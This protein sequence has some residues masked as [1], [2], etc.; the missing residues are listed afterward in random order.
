MRLAGS[1]STLLIVILSAM[2]SPPLIDDVHARGSEPPFETEHKHRPL[3]NLIVVALIGSIIAFWGMWRTVPAA[4]ITG[5]SL[6][7]LSFLIGFFARNGTKKRLRFLSALVVVSLGAAAVLVPWYLA[8]HES[9]PNAIW[10]RDGVIA[11]EMLHTD[12]H[13]LVRDAGGITALDINTGQL[14]WSYKDSDVYNMF[15]SNDGHVL[16]SGKDLTW[17]SPDGEELWSIERG[18]KPVAAHG[19][20]VTLQTCPNDNNDN[21][22]S[23]DPQADSCFITS[24]DASNRIVAEYGTNSAWQTNLGIAFSYPKQTDPVHESIG[25]PRVL[26]S[27]FI[28]TSDEEAVQVVDVESHQTTEISATKVLAISKDIVLHQLRESGTDACELV[29]MNAS[30]KQLWREEMPCAE[31]GIVIEDRYYA[32]IDNDDPDGLDDTLTVDIATGTWREFGP[33]RL[34]NRGHDPQTAEL[35]SDI[36]IER[37]H[38]QLTGIDPDTG[39]QRWQTTIPG[40]AT[41]G[42]FAAHGGVAVLSDQTAGINPFADTAL[43][44][45]VRLINGNTGETVAH[46][47]RHRVP[48]ELLPISDE[49]AL[50]SA[51]NILLFGK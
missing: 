29:G 36:V 25:K 31:F 1:D 46:Y 13:V 38:Q 27:V 33:S 19:D 32:P 41:P 45:S 50:V 4:Y 3:Q 15:V 14:T 21:D 6:I 9:S 43:G 28:L 24:I 8:E 49:R 22:S 44:T 2:H 20:T 37:D 10:A 47:A 5:V 11:L 7:V 35:G 30:G 17:L 18:P 42:V 26:P 34:W 12:D 40:E 51:E 23:G 39:K 16:A 48:W